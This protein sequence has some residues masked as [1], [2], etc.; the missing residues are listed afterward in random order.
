MKKK[1]NIS[2]SEVPPV[3]LKTLRNEILNYTD[4]KEHQSFTK[5]LDS[6]TTNKIIMGAKN[7][8]KSFG[9]MI[10]TIFRIVNEPDY[11]CVWARNL[12]TDI[13]NTVHPCFQKALDFLK[14]VH[15]LDFT[16]FFEIYT[17][18]VVYKPTGQ[19]IFFANF[20]LV[21]SFAGLTLKKANFDICDVFFDEIQQN[22]DELGSQLEKIYTKQPADMQF[23]RQATILR[24]K[25]KLGQQRRMVFLF[26]IYDSNHWICEKYVNKIMPFNQATREE[27]LAK[28]Y[29]FRE[30]LNQDDPELKKLDCSLLR[31]S[32]YYVPANEIDEFQRAEYEQLKLENP[33]LYAITIAGDPYDNQ[34]SSIIYPFKRFILDENNQP[35]EDLITY[36]EFNAADYMM[37]VDGF[38]PG[39][40]DKNGFCRAG[41][42][43]DFQIV[44]L[45]TK[46]ISSNDFSNFK[47]L[48]SVEYI[49]AIAEGLNEQEGIKSS[50][51][52]ID[53]KDDVIIEF[54]CK[55]IAENN[56]NIQPIKAI[57]NKNPNFVIDFNIQNRS[58][59]FLEC[60]QKG[61]IKF[62]EGTLQLLDYMT[63]MAY[64]QDFDRQEKINPGIYD[65]IN[66]ME[67]AVS[68]FYQ[69]VVIN[70]NFNV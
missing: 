58:K 24:T 20:E 27:L 38:D 13:I 54:A 66:A 65:L 64:N 18:V 17:K 49:L 55:Y 23:I 42:T 69:F 67:Y 2:T 15:N 12:S 60:F 28:N 57:K 46:E 21:N 41:L 51:L 52:A 32:R 9:C 4:D 40:N 62:S 6:P 50:I 10:E 56:L 33:K 5:C 31:M 63:K 68:I 48:T 35:Y 11:C 36:E 3:F 26:N 8:S 43:N 1:E 19:A 70:N 39:L 47:R 29:I 7:V 61:I 22:P 34:S 25:R 14:V 53:S 44:I 30:S 37:I 45:A 16:Q 59:F